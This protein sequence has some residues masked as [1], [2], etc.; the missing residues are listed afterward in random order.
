M[1]GLSHP[2]TF[3]IFLLHLSNT[4]YKE[5]ID[6]YANQLEGRIPSELA[7]LPKLWKLDLHDNNLIGTMPAEICRRKLP[8]LI[9]DCLG[10]APEV[11]CDCCTVCCAGLPHMICKDVKTGQTVVPS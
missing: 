8:V 5:V 9:A 4:K 3:F 1:L 6:L 11:K 10:S 2:H 7:L